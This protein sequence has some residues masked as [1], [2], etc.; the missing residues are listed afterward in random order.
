M[1]KLGILIFF[2]TFFCK[3]AIS[4][5]FIQNQK[6]S[7]YIKSSR[8]HKDLDFYEK[9]LVYRKS[10]KETVII[11]S[12]DP[13]EDLHFSYEYADSTM[14]YLCFTLG[15]EP[16]GS[17]KSIIFDKKSKLFYLT[18]SYN[19][20]VNGEKIIHNSIN[21]RKKMLIVKPEDSSG[22]HSINFKQ[23]WPSLKRGVSH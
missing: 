13:E 8:Y 4:E 9:I 12:S 21:F 2:V 14:S 22:P 5:D 3:Y 17:F 18:E 10:G 16:D 7:V 11:R 19:L 1:K 6:D 15:N 23:I 20:A